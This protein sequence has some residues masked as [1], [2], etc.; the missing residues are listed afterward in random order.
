MANK[1]VLENRPYTGKD[2]LENIND[3]TPIVTNKGWA[4][5]DMPDHEPTPEEQ[6]VQ[7]LE[8]VPD[9]DLTV[10]EKN[11]KKRYGDLRRHSQ[12]MENR[13]KKE[14]DDALK[15]LEDTRKAPVMSAEQLDRIRQ[16]YPDAVATI[17]AVTDAKVKDLEAKI[18][19]A[20][21]EKAVEK[22]LRVIAEQHPDWEEIRNDNNFHEWAKSQPEAIQ[23][24]VYVN[25][26]KGDLAAKA[27]SM[28]KAEK[29][30]NKSAPRSNNKADASRLVPSAGTVDVPNAKRI[31]TAR[32]IQMLT[33]RQYDKFE[34][35]IK[36]ARKEGR[37]TR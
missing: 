35:D 25:E 12:D 37:I 33:S 16:E 2:Q 13:L 7:E 14:R 34:A 3:D 26:T 9:A 27:V 36:L 4:F 10:D 24:W 20:E 21:H 19:K 18:N 23:D 28:Y 17:S 5:R 11:F 8:K 31:W 32:E 15:A 22:A 6:L 1:T 29:G 30:L